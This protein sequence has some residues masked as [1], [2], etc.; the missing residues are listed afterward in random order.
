MATPDVPNAFM[1]TD[2]PRGKDG[3]RVMMK[4]IGQ[5]VDALVEV[6]PETCSKHVA[7]GAMRL[8]WLVGNPGGYEP[9]MGDIKAA[10][11]EAMSHM[12]HAKF[13]LTFKKGDK[14]HIPCKAGK[15][16]IRGNEDFY[17]ALMT[18]EGLRKLRE[19]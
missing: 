9:T 15:K 18:V 8:Q 1:Q 12:T 2:Q 11:I 6:A 16:N 10:L 4:L 14:W 3:E 5:A 13:M 7:Q 19:R 17:H